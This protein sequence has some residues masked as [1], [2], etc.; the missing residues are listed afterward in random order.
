MKALIAAFAL[1]SFVAA[2]TIPVAAQAATK[3]TH[4]TTHK[5]SKKKHV[6]QNT[7][8]PK[9]SHKHKTPTSKTTG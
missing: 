8:K 2:T 4:Q 9:K 1:L 3:T 5:K 6:A 7:K